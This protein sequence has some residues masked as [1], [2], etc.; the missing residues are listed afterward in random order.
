M[1]QVP[2]PHAR[3]WP[4]ELVEDELRLRPLRRRDARVWSQ[5]RAANAAWLA[6]WEATHPE[7]SGRPP[8]FAQMTRSFTREARA[9]RM[10]PW[11]MEVEGRL[12]GQLTV[13]GITWGSLRAAHVGYWVDQRLAGRGITPTAV[14]MASDYCFLTLGLH[15]IEIN[16]RPDNHASLRVVDK[17]GFRSEGV[18]VRYL[19]IDGGWRDHLSFALTTEDVPE[20]LLAAWRRTRGA[21]RAT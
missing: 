3:P 4:V 2:M 21:R 17:L 8:T 7:E 16:I 19:H 12:A 9:G 18:R 13:A 15:R 10:L 6:P 14:A 11:V 20:G 1:S 5:V